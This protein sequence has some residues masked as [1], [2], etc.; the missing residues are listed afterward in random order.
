MT[1]RSAAFRVLLALPVLAAALVAGQSARA[2]ETKVPS[3]STSED[4]L[5]YVKMTTSKGDIVLELNE[6][7]APISVANFLAYVDSGF[8][9]G[10]IFHRV[11]PNF[12]IQGGGF[13]PDMEQKKT[14]DPIKNEWQNGLKN[15][16]GTIAM[17]RTNVADSA[18]SQFFINVKDNDFLDEPR[19]G[20]AYAVFGQVVDGMDVVTAIEHVPT[21]SKGMHKNVPQEPVLIVKVMRLDG[22]KKKN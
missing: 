3:T 2:Q 4:K 14:N 1:A 8:Y 12:M 20:A 11:M 15:Q 17:A 22:Y 7:K 13:T 21:G 10:T 18:T 16:K 5:V 9:N 19:D 6:T